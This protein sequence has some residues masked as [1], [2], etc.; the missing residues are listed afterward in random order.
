MPVR[1][2]TRHP[3][4]CF[5]RRPAHL[6]VEFLEPRSLPSVTS[7]PGLVN[8]LPEAE[9]NDRLDL[10]PDLGDLNTRGPG[11]AVGTISPAADV[12]WYTFSLT[13]A[14]HV[15]LSTLG[16]LAQTSL[17]SEL[18]LFNSDPDDWAD[19]Y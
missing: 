8:P 10:A 11:E 5:L 18:S 14:S 1:T 16:A 17:V 3:R 15:V 7:W 2:R 19:P 9:P 4:R 13:R 12:D 6:R